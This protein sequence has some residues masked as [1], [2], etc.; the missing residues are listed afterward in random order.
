M[1]TTLT[2]QLFA[3]SEEHYKDYMLVPPEGYTQPAWFVLYMWME[4]FFHVPISLWSVP[5]LING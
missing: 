3:Y 1:K 4:L 5:G 2:K